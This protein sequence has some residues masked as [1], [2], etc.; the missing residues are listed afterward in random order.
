[1]RTRATYRLAAQFAGIVFVQCPTSL[2][3]GP[4]CLV[5]VGARFTKRRAAFTRGGTAE[6]RGRCAGEHEADA[7]DESDV[8]SH[9]A[10]I[11]PGEHQARNARSISISTLRTS[12]GVRASRGN[13]MRSGFVPS[14]VSARTRMPSRSTPVIRPRF[15]LTPAASQYRI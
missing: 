11:L 9:S 5:D 8:P 6:L 15:A 14:S 7:G 2:M 13:S 10:K 12:F 1:D 3:N 4:A